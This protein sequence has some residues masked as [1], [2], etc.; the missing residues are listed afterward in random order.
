MN[1]LLKYRNSLYMDLFCS[2]NCSEQ[3]A[4]NFSEKGDEA[5]LVT[6]VRDRR[7]ERFTRRQTKHAGQGQAGSV[8]GNQAEKHWKVL[9][10]KEQSGN[11]VSVRLE[12]KCRA[13]LL[14]MSCRWVIGEWGQLCRV[15]WGGAVE[16]E[17]RQRNR[18][19]LW[20]TDSEANFLH[21]VTHVNLILGWYKFKINLWIASETVG[22]SVKFF[23]PPSD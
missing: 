13:W 7:L 2:E 14:E 23:Q 11:W 16:N 5:G 4:T 21:C 12:P 10:G 6:C 9:H 20:Q 17:S 18:G 8:L 1:Y 3:A 22:V 19:R 15:S